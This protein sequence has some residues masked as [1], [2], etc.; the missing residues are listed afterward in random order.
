MGGVSVKSECAELGEVVH[1]LLLVEQ[2][3]SVVL[4]STKLRSSK[5]RLHW[6]K[7]HSLLSHAGGNDPS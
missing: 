5:L 2:K 3:M 1:A 7:R 6:H 4:K